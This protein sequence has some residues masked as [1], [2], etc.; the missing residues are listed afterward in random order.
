MHGIIVLCQNGMSISQVMSFFYIS[1]DILLILLSLV[2][3]DV[4]LVFFVA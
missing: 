1:L 4:T 2:I 3:A